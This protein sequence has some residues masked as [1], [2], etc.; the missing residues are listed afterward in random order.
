MDGVSDMDLLSARTYAHLHVY[1]VVA[2]D[3]IAKL[4]DQCYE[5]S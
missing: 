4:G 2:I 5:Y 3:T 1:I